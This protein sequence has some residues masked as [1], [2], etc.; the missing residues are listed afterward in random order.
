VVHAAWPSIP[1]GGLLDTDLAAVQTQVEFGT[2]GTIRVARFLRS[3][4]LAAGARLVLLGTT[5]ATVKPVLNMGAYSLGKAA[6]EHTAKLLAPELARSNITVNTVA[7]S[8]VPVGMNAS[9]TSRVVLSESARVP[10]GKLC[11]PEDVAGAVEFFLSPGA[12]FVTGQILPL[13]GGQ[14]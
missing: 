3:H 5:A 10:L 9:K 1:Q 12:A 6:L 13:T 2:V 11:S 4:A 7:P 8:F 14:L